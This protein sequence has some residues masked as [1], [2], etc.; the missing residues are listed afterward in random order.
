MTASSRWFALAI[1]LL[2]SKAAFAEPYF[3]QREGYRCSKCHVNRTGGGMRTAFGRQYAMTHLTMLATAPRDVD[4][5]EE[6]NG[7]QRRAWWTIDPALND[8][9][10]FGA[11]IRVDSLTALANEVETTFTNPE[12]NLYVALDATHFATAYFDVSL[13][14]GSVQAR[15]AFLLLHGGGFRLKGGIILLPYGLRIWDED[16]FIRSQTGFNYA[17]PDLGVELGYENGPFGLFVAVSNGAGGGLDNDRD[18][19]LSGLIEWAG[20]WWR[21]GGSASYNRTSQ[22]EDF[23][24]GGFAGLTLG[25]LTLLGEVDRLSTFFI[26]E[27]EAIVS[28]VAYG[29]ANFLVARGLNLKVAYGYHDPSIDVDE[30]QRFSLLTG[31]EIFPAPFLAARAFYEFRGSVPQDEVGNADLILVEV[32]VYL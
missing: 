14:E 31:V 9:V 21:L 20:S 19:Q 18:K 7:L 17:S 12:A 22:T 6:M 26:E 29:E 28:L 24:V 11:D 25:R 3:A 27:D 13:A 4:V 30:N 16:Q 23:F 5:V 8:Y 15:E 2:A 32:H 10:A 1:T